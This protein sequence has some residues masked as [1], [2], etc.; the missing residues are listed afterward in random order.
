MR[1]T[2][3]ANRRSEAARKANATR[4]ARRLFEQRYGTTSYY[5]VG[6]IFRGYSTDEICDWNNIARQ[7][8]A[9]YR[10]NLCRSG[11][12]SL[13]ARACNF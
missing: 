8:L 13:L 11:N 6:D 10:A 2:N 7:S 9:A 1:K 12:F 4:A 3:T 5:V